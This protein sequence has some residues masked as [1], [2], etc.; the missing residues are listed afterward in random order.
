MAMA[1]DQETGRKREGEGLKRGSRE[2]NMLGRE[3]EATRKASISGRLG[4]DAT[5]AGAGSTSILE[6]QERHWDRL[7]AISE[8]LW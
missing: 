3:I 4:E 6:T 2:H 1:G 5:T 8:E 7:F